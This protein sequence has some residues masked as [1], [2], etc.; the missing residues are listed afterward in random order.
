[1]STILSSEKPDALDTNSQERHVTQAAG[2]VTR[3]VPV[4]IFVAVFGMF[5]VWPL[6]DVLLRSLSDS[7]VAHYF[8]PHVSFANYTAIASTSF[9]RTLLWQTVYISILSAVVAL[10]LATPVAYLMSRV[11]S[12]VAMTLMAFI[13]V[14]FFSSIVVR[15]FGLSELLGRDGPVNQLLGSVGLGGPYSLLFNTFATVVGNVEYLV[16]IAILTLYSAMNRVDQNMLVAARTL[17]ARGGT[18]FIRIYLP[19]IRS[20][21]LATAALCFILSAGF[22]LTPSMLGGT[23]DT[24]IPLYV[25]Q[26]VQ[27]Y[28]WGTASAV[29]IVLLIL[30]IAG[31]YVAM[32]LG[33][34]SLFAA[35]HA[36]G[37]GVS[38]E[39]RLGLS[40]TSVLLWAISLLLILALLAP[41]AIVVAS[42]FN[43]SPFLEFPPHD[44]TTKWYSAALTDPTW[45]AAI[46]K[47]VRVALAVGII[48]TGLGLLLA[49]V[50]SK[51]DRPW[52]ADLVGVIA[53][54]PLVVPLVLLAI[55]IFG[56]EARIGLLGTQIGLILP[57]SVLT[58]PY[59][60]SILEGA[61]ARGT[62]EIELAAWTLGASRTRTF[63]SVII[64]RL[65]PSLF[66]SFALCFVMSW[67]EIMVALFQTGFNKTLPVLIYSTVKS[68]PNPELSAIATVAMGVIFMGL[69]LAGIYR[70]LVP[71]LSRSR[72][73]A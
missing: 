33:R 41:L 18:A 21:L 49:R 62:D 54:T 26:Q 58:V 44:L 50:K 6:L 63:W 5:F 25:V 1:M 66:A 61:M 9:L 42:S 43:G 4:V 36:G 3:A 27:N 70:L 39:V 38:S 14:E 73:P 7:G 30:S 64:P 19:Q 53:F 47:S 11:S 23:S 24:T 22:F 35:G 59:A 60:Y 67:D 15:L 34:G 46:W 8:W 69:I 2:R 56:V 71:R 45:V 40:V 48:G 37:K 17:G 28:T 55:G 20:S 68:G 52:L 72:T 31:Y 13:V 12:R 65:I 29:G 57:Q 10:A 16:P 51:I 32:R